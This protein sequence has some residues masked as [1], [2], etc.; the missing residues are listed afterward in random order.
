MKN[1]LVFCVILIV[2]VMVSVLLLIRILICEVCVLG[3]FCYGGVT[4]MA[5][6]DV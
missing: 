1:Y 4:T 3:I 6:G 2:F 5:I